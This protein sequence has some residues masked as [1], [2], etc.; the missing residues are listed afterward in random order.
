MLY[1][2]DFNVQRRI[3]IVDSVAG[4]CITIAGEATPTLDMEIG[5]T[6]QAAEDIVLPNSRLMDFA[7][8]GSGVLVTDPKRGVIWWVG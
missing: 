6:Q 7:V 2:R 8:D 4:E 5:Q 3:S 1:I